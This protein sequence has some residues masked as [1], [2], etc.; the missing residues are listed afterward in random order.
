MLHLVF[1][2]GDILHFNSSFLCELSI[3]SHSFHQIVHLSCTHCG[4]CKYIPSNTHYP[5]PCSRTI[6]HPT[7]RQKRHKDP[8][9]QTNIYKAACRRVHLMCGRKRRQP[10]AVA[11]WCVLPHQ[12]K[13][14]YIYLC[15]LSTSRSGGAPHKAQ[16]TIE[17][18]EA[19]I[20][21]L[22]RSTHQLSDGADHNRKEKCQIKNDSNIWMA[23]ANDRNLGELCLMGASSLSFGAVCALLMCAPSFSGRIIN[24]TNA[25]HRKEP[26]SALARVLL[27]R[28][29]RTQSLFLQTTRAVPIPPKKYI[30]KSN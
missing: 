15:Y 24:K 12:E 16:R 29:K 10:L 13:V 23:N 1:L 7:K 22:A 21:K 5:S 30:F 17:A 8:H 26:R 25:I 11:H 27:N 14:Y 20:N 9:W 28:N 18:I 19:T 3:S 2:E 6:R 4:L